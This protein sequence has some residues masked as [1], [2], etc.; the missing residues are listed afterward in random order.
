M[1]EVNHSHL[2]CFMKTATFLSVCLFL[3]GCCSAASAQDKSTSWEMSPA[4]TA[5]WQHVQARYYDVAVDG[6]PTNAFLQRKIDELNQSNPA[7]FRAPSWPE[8]LAAQC[9]AELDALKRA[10]PNFKPAPQPEA[11]A[12]AAQAAPMGSVQ[13]VTKTPN[14]QLI[15]PLDSTCMFRRNPALTGS[16]VLTILNGTGHYAIVKLIN[17]QTGAVD[18]EFG[19]L[20]GQKQAF[21]S[22]PDGTYSIVFAL[23][24]NLSVEAPGGFVPSLGCSRFDQP[25]VFTTRRENNSVISSDIFIT[26]NAVPGGNARTRA[27]TEEEYN[28]W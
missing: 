12:P 9:E 20:A 1:H 3:T 24:E 11:T 23:G 14:V 21:T 28:K 15:R 5:S 26:L 27:I 2:L 16:G 13:P 8:T 17:T 4:E 19:V 25:V 18:F 6:S 7:F 22:L 10:S